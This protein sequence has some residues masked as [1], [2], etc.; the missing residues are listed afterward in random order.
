MATRIGG[1]RTSQDLTQSL[2]AEISSIAQDTVA[3]ETS[4]TN[5]LTRLKGILDDDAIAASNEFRKVIDELIE[6]WT[7][8]ARAFQEHRWASQEVAIK[9]SAS[10]EDFAEVS[11]QVVT[12]DTVTHEEK[13]ATLND[14]IENLKEEIKKSK[15]LADGFENLQFEIGQFK[16]DWERIIQKYNNTLKQSA[17]TK[18]IK[19]EIQNLG[20][21]IKKYH[22]KITT[23]RTTVHF[24]SYI[25]VFTSVRHKKRQEGLLA[26][27]DLELSTD[28]E[29]DPDGLLDG[30]ATNSNQLAI[31]FQAHKVLNECLEE[32]VPDMDIIKKGTERFRS[33]W[34]AV[35]SK[36]SLVILFTSQY[37]FS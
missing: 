34:T 35:C 10:A 26:L 14:Y 24:L 29:S 6:K 17:K 8:H 25:S 2:L 27:S 7:I 28:T 30:Q 9:A 13:I 33:V 15:D 16:D 31:T 11:L 32:C 19:S 22:S 12:N 18:G 4:F 37:G 23:L 36:S 3:I 1:Q 20:N 5:V 21:K